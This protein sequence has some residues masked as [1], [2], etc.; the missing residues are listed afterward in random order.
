MFPL[1]LLAMLSHQSQHHQQKRLAY[2]KI[3]QTPTKPP[4]APPI[5]VELKQNAYAHKA[6]T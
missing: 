2:I 3:K 5:A 4:K 1:P 6:S